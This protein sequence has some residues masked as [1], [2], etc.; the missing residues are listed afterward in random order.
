MSFKYLALFFVL[1]VSLGMVFAADPT[2]T[3]NTRH[4]SGFVEVVGDRNYFATP[5]I[6]QSGVVADADLDFNVLSCQYTIFDTNGD[7][8]VTWLEADWN[9]DVNRCQVT[10]AA[11]GGTDDFNFNFRVWD[12][13]GGDT[14]G[15]P[16]YSWLDEAVPSTTVT[17]TTYPTYT[18][19]NVVNLDFATTTGTGANFTQLQYMID[20]NGTWVTVTD[21]NFDVNMMLDDFTPGTHE[22]QYWAI[23]DLDNNTGLTI[24]NFEM[25]GRA[26][27][28][29]GLTSHASGFYEGSDRNYFN[30]TTR[31]LSGVVA[32]ADL[33]FNTSA[34]YYTAY[35]T[36][37]T[38]PVT[39]LSADWNADTNQCQVTLIGVSGTDDFNF[40][41]R[42]YDD[43]GNDTNGL[44][45][46]TWLDSN[47]PTSADT[48]TSSYNYS[49][50]A[51]TGTDVA[52]NTGSGSGSETIYYSIDGA[53]WVSTADPAS[54]EVRGG[55]EHTVYYYALDNL[56]NNEG[57][58]NTT[59]FTVSGMT[60]ATCTLLP[61]VLLALAAVVIIIILGLAFTDN[62][63]M[64]TLAALGVTL[65]SVLIIMYMSG[66]F[67][68]QVCS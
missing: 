10:I 43:Y 3:G 20:D 64:T 6:I 59:T 54:V 19:I 30:P 38:N 65:I 33:D 45:A 31:I 27:T 35:D 34:C 40:N 26:P 58:P 8:P 25:T 16:A 36:N 50:V 28:I 22:F 47:A 63:N 46:Y 2:I 7:N 41:F 11:V 66:V 61:T 17:S 13:A 68:G 44:P 67:V 52:T 42:V 32:D 23:D 57:T 37:G 53:A 4:I 15:I 18:N 14:N 62:L 5:T 51:I 39:W 12:D 21:N 56:D 24:E 55:G 9:A 49:T 60:T 48:V 1:I 29:T